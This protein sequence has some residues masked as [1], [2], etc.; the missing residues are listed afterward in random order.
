MRE[1][2]ERGSDLATQKAFIEAT[3]AWLPAFKFLGMG[4]LLGGVTFLLATILG[5]LR[6]GGG[7]VQQA[8]GVEV[9]IIKPPSTAKLFPPIMMMGTMVLLAALIIGIVLATLTYDYWNHSIAAQ[10]NPSTGALLADLGAINAIKLWLEPFKFVGMALLL[11]G[12]GLALA[13]IVRVLRW[14]AN[15]LWEILS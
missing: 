12:I 10:L 8:L 11:T 6:I 7:R 4:M 15:R 1:A 3:K 13:T 9:T 5:A 14:Q 2:A